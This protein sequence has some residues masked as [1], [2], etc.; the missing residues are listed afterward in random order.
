M[1]IVLALLTLFLA[2]C[3]IPANAPAAVKPLLSRDGA[4]RTA[5]KGDD[6]LRAALAGAGADA[7]PSLFRGR[8]LTTLRLQVARLTERG[9]LFE[10]RSVSRRLARFDAASGEA[11]LAVSSEYRMATRE[12]I[13]PA[14][15]ATERQWWMRFEFDAGSWWIVEQQNLPPD[16]WVHT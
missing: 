5:F 11:V 6:L 1:R 4:E 14:W 10:E 16:R 8:A 12:E 3:A 9:V 15:A 7:L 13:N 2:G